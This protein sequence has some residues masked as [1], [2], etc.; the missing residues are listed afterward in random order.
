MKYAVACIMAV[1]V[2]GISGCGD[3]ATNPA[4]GAAYF[5]GEIG[6][7]WV[8]SVYDSLTERSYDMTVTVVDS[9]TLRD[10]PVSVW[11][12][13]GDGRIDTQYVYRSADT[14]T[15]YSQSGWGFAKMY[16]FPVEVGK[17]W[18]CGESCRHD[19]IVD[20]RESIETPAGRFENAYHIE[21]HYFIPNDI[22]DS[23]EWFVPGVGAVWFYRFGMCSACYP[24][25]YVNQ[26]WELKSYQLPD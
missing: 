14:V 2:M 9:A 10:L 1:A 24:M 5:P 25:I 23:A 3:E 11:V 8:Y 12:Y 19:Y 18:N 22:E 17:G 13:Y 15:T 16:V 7:T 6:T 20:R 26:V 21:G 4:G